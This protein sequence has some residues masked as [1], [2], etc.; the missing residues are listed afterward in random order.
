[1]PEIEFGGPTAQGSPPGT[2]D[3]TSLRGHVLLGGVQ[4]VWTVEIAR[5]RHWGARVWPP[6]A[7]GR[8][9]VVRP[10]E[11]A[12]RPAVNEEEDLTGAMI[13]A[14]QQ[15]HR[16]LAGGHPPEPETHRVGYEAEDAV[17][18]AG[19]ECP[20]RTENGGM[21]C[22]FPN[23]HD[24]LHS[25]EVPVCGEVGGRARNCTKAHGHDGPHSWEGS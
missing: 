8:T 25:W 18:A 13:W 19:G 2:C 3:L 16:D 24:G 21:A 10:V 7:A 23:H 9:T 17:A 5:E 11:V 6:G 15:A 20:A 12:A 14:A 1:M 4:G 22:T